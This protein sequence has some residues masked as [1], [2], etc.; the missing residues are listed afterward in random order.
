MGAGLNLRMS[1]TYENMAGVGLLMEIRQGR[2]VV[3]ALRYL[4]CVVQYRNWA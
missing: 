1:E 4:W 3:T 2:G